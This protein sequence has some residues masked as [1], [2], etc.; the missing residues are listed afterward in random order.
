MIGKN[1]QQIQH[2][3]SSRRRQSV[4]SVISGG[5]RVGARSHASI[6]QLVQYAFMRMRQRAQEDEMLESVREAIVGVVPAA[7]AA[8]GLRGQDDVKAAHRL[9]RADDEASEI[10]V[11]GAI[12]GDCAAVGRGVGRKLTKC[13]GGADN[14]IRGAVGPCLMGGG[15]GRCHDCF[16]LCFPCQSSISF[17]THV[18]TSLDYW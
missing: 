7:V 1:G 2:S 6:G 4:R 3:L 15:D 5:P 9:V 12:G 16:D 18:C 10:G 8:V 11:G 14:P 17:K 13:W